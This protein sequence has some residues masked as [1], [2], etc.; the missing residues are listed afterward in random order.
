MAKKIPKLDPELIHME[1]LRVLKAHFEIN[2]E[3][4][5]EQLEIASFGMDTESEPGYNLSE[6]RMK[7]RLAI[8]LTGFDSEEKPL[9]IK[10]DYIFEFLYSIENLNDF[11][12]NNENG[13]IQMESVLGATIAGISYSTARGI[14]LDRTQGT[15]FNGILLP[16]V[17]PVSLLRES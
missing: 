13:E 10:A 6:N 5:D 4:I 15:D 7:F 17:N 2:K 3:F 9:K 16:I 8:G 14:I 1:S 12:I 11:V